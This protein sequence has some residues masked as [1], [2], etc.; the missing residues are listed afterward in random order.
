MTLISIPRSFDARKPQGH[1]IESSV[2]KGGNVSTANVDASY[3]HALYIY[4]N[5]AFSCGIYFAYENS[6]VLEPSRLGRRDRF[7]ALF[8]APAVHN[9][10][11]N[12]LFPLCN[13]HTAETGHTQVFVRFA[14]LFFFSLVQ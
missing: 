13:F 4:V 14:A 7:C 1:I 3:E 2:I 11:S 6:V 12:P 9:K 8:R 10:I 5:V